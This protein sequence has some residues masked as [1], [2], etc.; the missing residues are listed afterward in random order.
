MARRLKLATVGTG[1]FAEFHFEAWSR[2]ENVDL[3]GLC[4]LDGAKGRTI[5]DRFDV[6][7]V[8][9]DVADMLDAVKPDLLDIVTPP[10][11]HRQFIETAVLRGV[12]VVCQKPFTENLAEAEEMTVLA[13]AKGVPL[14]VHEIFVFNRSIAKL[15]RS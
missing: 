8:H 6:D 10:P 2:I 4:T 13:E 5:A 9:G 14:I 1:Y 11:T 15:V 7:T 12:A 3:V